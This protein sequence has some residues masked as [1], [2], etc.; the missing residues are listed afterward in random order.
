MM[1]TKLEKIEKILDRSTQ[2]GV[3]LLLFSL[4]AGLVMRFHFLL[5]FVPRQAKQSGGFWNYL[6]GSG[7]YEWY[8]SDPLGLSLLLLCLVPA[9]IGLSLIFGGSHLHDNISKKVLDEQ[10]K[11]EVNKQKSQH[12]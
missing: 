10:I 8:L 5:S 3:V 12:I 1:M 9:L 7:E 6:T 2:V 11:F 4:M